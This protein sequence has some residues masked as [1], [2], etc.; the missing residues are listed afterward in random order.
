LK[1]AAGR[2]RPVSLEAAHSK[3]EGSPAP[4]RTI[5]G[6]SWRSSIT[7]V[8]RAAVTRV[9]HR[10]EASPTARDLP[11]LVIG[12]SWPAAAAGRDERLAELFD[13]ALVTGGWDP[14]ADGL[15]SRVLQAAG[16]LF[17]ASRMKV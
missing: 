4:R 10:V 9:D 5:C 15:S 3:S 13:S 6:S 14:H 7:V 11:A 1:A 12:S 8:A 16:H 2:Q 17:V